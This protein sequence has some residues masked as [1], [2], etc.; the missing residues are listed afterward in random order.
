[1]VSRFHRPIG[2]TQGRQFKLFVAPRNLQNEWW[3]QSRLLVIQQQSPPKES[4]R[5]WRSS[6][7]DL[8]TNSRSSPQ[9]LLDYSSTNSKMH[10]ASMSWSLLV[11]LLSYFLLNRSRKTSDSTEELIPSYDDTGEQY[12]WESM[13]PKLW[14]LLDKALQRKRWANVFGLSYNFKV[15]CSNLVSKDVILDLLT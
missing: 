14:S 8:F 7:V 2:H 6:F 15:N 13:S 10:P 12:T 9:F 5:S 3:L 1:M 11:F 4:N